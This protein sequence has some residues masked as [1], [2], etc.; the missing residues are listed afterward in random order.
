M[1]LTSE[2]RRNK[3]LQEVLLRNEVSVNDLAD[4]FNV[5]TE[6]IRKDIAYLQEK[7]LLSKKHGMATIANPFSENEF[8]EKERQYVDEKNKIAEI[9]IS[10]IPQNASVFLDT[11]TTV[12]QL[13][14]LLVMRQDLTIITNSMRINQVLSNSENQILLTGG[15]YRKISSSYVGDW[16]LSVINKLNI[17]LAFIGCDGFS[18]NGPTLQ[19][20]Q[21]LEIKKAV[22]DHSKK[23]IL[24]CDTSK[25]TNEGLYTF[26]DYSDLDTVIFERSLTPKERSQFPE[27]LFLFSKS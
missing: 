2:E 25:L 9:A 3:I 23:A 6:T 1:K 15:L 27:S 18:E 10:L 21:E 4:N 12:Y 13:A 8:S 22:I 24:L 19:A 16:T 17:D 20:Y 11:S 7:N 14:K 26:A 5:S